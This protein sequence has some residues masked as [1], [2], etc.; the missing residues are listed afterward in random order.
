MDIPESDASAVASSPSKATLYAFKFAGAVFDESK[1]LLTVDGQ[2]VTVEPRPL[3]VLAELLHHANEVVT[4]EELF[5][6]VWDGRVTVDNVLANAITKLR[7]AL[8]D[9]AGGRIVNVP[10]IGYRLTGPVERVAVGQPLALRLKLEPGAPVPGRTN[11]VLVRALG[12]QGQGNVWLAR[13]PKTGQERVFKFAVDAAGLSGLKREYTLSRVLRAQLGERPGLVSVH[14]ANFFDSPFSL[15]SEYVGPD[16]LAWHTASGALDQLTQA[17]RVNLFL[18]VARTIASAHA[19]GMLHKD[20]KPANVLVRESLGSHAAGIA[21]NDASQPHPTLVVADFGSGHLAD[22]ERIRHL[23]ITEMGLTLSHVQSAAQA[24]GTLMYLAPEVQAGQ[25][26]TVQSDVFALGV[27]LYQMVTAQ[28]T[29]PLSTGWERDVDD[30]L[31]RDDIAAATQGDAA[32]RSASAATLVQ[33]LTALDERRALRAKQVNEEAAMLVTRDDLRRRQARRPW[34]VAT[35]AALMLGLAVSLGLWRQSSQAEQRAL[36]QSARAKVVSGFAF[37]DVLESTDLLNAGADAKPVTVLSKLR[38]AAEAASVRFADQPL[39]EAEAQTSLAQ[40]FLKL[41]ALNEAGIAMRRAQTLLKPLLAQNDP[42]LLK[43]R[44]MTAHWL[45]WTEQFEKGEAELVAA[46]QVLV[47]KLLADEPE[48]A[49]LVARAR[50]LLHR[51]KRELENWKAQQLKLM[52]LTE[53]HTA[54]G[55]PEQLD[56]IQQYGESLIWLG[57]KETAQV[58]LDKLAQPPFNVQGAFAEGMLKHHLLM[59]QRA[60]HSADPVLAADQ[61]N[62]ALRWSAQATQARRDWLECWIQKELGTA[63]LYAG[64]LEEGAI[65]SQRGYDLVVKVSGAD[66]QYAQAFSLGIA[67]NHLMQG[68]F[69]FALEIFDQ[70]EATHLAAYGKQPYGPVLDFGRARAL[71]GLG[72]AVQAEPLLAT[73]DVKKLIRLNYQADAPAQAAFWHGLAL[74]R[75]GQSAQGLPKMRKALADLADKS[76][77]PWA[78]PRWRALLAQAGQT[79]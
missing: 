35:I 40:T 52:A 74:A 22:S 68:K 26:A 29:R 76:T 73:L 3:R 30:P 41:A 23:G 61:L 44:V 27:L 63:L 71:I 14:D 37:R 53:L 58:T 18:Q 64:K 77:Y 13:Q 1:L 55:S 70:I 60:L 54:P 4:K 19:L 24:G 20:I 43:L 50:A 59:G 79:P 49:I 57:Q 7:K 75:S 16:L 46:E 31:L 21:P 38:Q 11:F 17:E 36:A 8:G 12:A 67:E 6:S 33:Q 25:S 39:I 66:H 5:D 15:E 45:I 34:V 56:A 62:A 69:A 28:L 9:D 51:E 10:R 48:I 32:R 47:P 78:L 42:L 65:A 72:R 2:V